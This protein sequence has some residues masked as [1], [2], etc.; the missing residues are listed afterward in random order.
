ME[1]IKVIRVINSCTSLKQMKSAWN[2]MCLSYT[3]H[4]DIIVFSTQALIFRSKLSQLTG[5]S[6]RNLLDY[7]AYAEHL[8]HTGQI[9]DC[10][11]F[12]KFAELEL[13]KLCEIRGELGLY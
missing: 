12:I 8:I 5:A 2:Y 13:H 11:E 4:N 10:N 9:D 3:N 1:N 6:V 7:K